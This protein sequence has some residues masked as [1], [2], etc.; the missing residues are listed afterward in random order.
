MRDSRLEIARRQFCSSLLQNWDLNT[1][2]S[3]KPWHMK[4]MEQAGAL[5]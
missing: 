1:H 2:S 4:Q 3:H 5:R